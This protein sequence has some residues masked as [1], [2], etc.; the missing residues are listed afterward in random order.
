MRVRVKHKQY[1]PTNMVQ[2]A[3]ISVHICSS[4]LIANQQK[5]RDLNLPKCFYFSEF[6][7]S[8]NTFL[9]L[10]LQKNRNIVFFFLHSSNFFL[11]VAAAA[12]T[13]TVCLFGERRKFS[14]TF[15]F[16]YFLL[17]LALFV[18]VHNVLHVI[19]FVYCCCCCN[20]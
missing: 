4:T 20:W 13:R 3:S 19:C 5:K 14:A 16:F 7:C 15:L 17:L 10:S 6:G 12:G 1:K 9:K 11:F 8:N 2:H 18:N